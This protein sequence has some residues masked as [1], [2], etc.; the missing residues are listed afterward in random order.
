VFDDILRNTTHGVT[1]W[2]FSRWLIKIRTAIK[3]GNLTFGNALLYDQVE[4]TTYTEISIFKATK[5]DVAPR[6]QGSSGLKD[7][8]FPLARE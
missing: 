4:T 8:G 6:R 7:A 3:P 1:P 2:R 5:I